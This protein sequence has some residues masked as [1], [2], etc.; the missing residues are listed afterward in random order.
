M[1]II[2]ENRSKGNIGT[3]KGP[4]EPNL[5]IELSDEEA[6][7]LLKYPGII[8]AKKANPEIFKSYEADKENL[9]KLLN[10]ANI[11]KNNWIEKYNILLEKYNKEKNI[12]G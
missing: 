12:E 11:D 3:S 5:K 9:M 1:S 2:I 4:L 10:Q 8:D 7:R 6:N